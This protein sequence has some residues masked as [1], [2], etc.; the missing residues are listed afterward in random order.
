MA[1]TRTAS[2]NAAATLIS[3]TYGT[4]PCQTDSEVSACLGTTIASSILFKSSAS[5]PTF[6]SSERVCTNPSSSSNDRYQL[7]NSFFSETDMVPAQNLS[8]S[9]PKC[10]LSIQCCF[11]FYYY[12][13]FRWQH[14]PCVE[15]FF[16]KN[17]AFSTAT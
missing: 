5:K 14:P 1:A 13:H 10:L 8:S 4:N 12:S 7:S 11:G 17:N 15:H 3:V 9:R 16:L 2:D 6:S